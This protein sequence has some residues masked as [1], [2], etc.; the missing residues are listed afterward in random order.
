MNKSVKLA[1]KKSHSAPKFMVHG[2]AEELRKGK[3]GRPGD[4]PR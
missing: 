1:P 4:C 2:T 3:D